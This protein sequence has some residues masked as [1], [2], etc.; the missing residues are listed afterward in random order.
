M[1]HRLNQ[2][3]TQIMTT[4]VVKNIATLLDNNNIAGQSWATLLHN[5]LFY[6]IYSCAVLCCFRIFCTMVG[7]VPGMCFSIDNT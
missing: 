2:L 7:K 3:R 1:F 6:S 5:P 4:T